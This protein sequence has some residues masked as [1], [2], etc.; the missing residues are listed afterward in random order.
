MTLKLDSR[1]HKKLEFVPLKVEIVMFYKNFIGRHDD[2]LTNL[3]TLHQYYW[4]DYSQDSV[5]TN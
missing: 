2:I 4:E 3:Y 1:V 5:K